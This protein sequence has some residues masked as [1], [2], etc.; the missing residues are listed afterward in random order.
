M[1][2][3]SLFQSLD[4]QGPVF[5]LQSVHNDALVVTDELRDLV[6][7]CGGGVL[8]QQRVQSR[9]HLHHNVANDRVRQKFQEVFAMLADV[10]RTRAKLVAHFCQRR[11]IQLQKP[12]NQKSFFGIT[13]D[14]NSEI[15]DRREK[16]KYPQLRIN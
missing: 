5:A 2:L 10:V 9:L 15:S 8:M 7:V 13:G 4:R 16:N 14:S 12:A 3:I 1:R 11:Q 6:E